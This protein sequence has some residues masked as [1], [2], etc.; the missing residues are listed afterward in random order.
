MEFKH[1]LHNHNLTFI[2]VGKEN[3]TMSCFGC[4]DIICGPAYVCEKCNMFDMHK[5]CA[6]LPPQMQRDAFHPHPLRFTLGN[7]IVCDRCAIWRAFSFSYSCMNCTFNL[8]FR[9]AVTISND[10]ELANHEALQE[11]RRIKTTIHHF[12]HNHQLTRCKFS[13]L[14]TVLGKEIFK[15]LWKLEKPKCM[16][17]KQKLHDI[18]IYTCIPCRFVIH[19]SCVNDMPRQVLQG[20]FHPQH[21]LLPRLIHKGSSHRCSA[22][23]EEVKGISFYCNQC[24]VNMHV[25]CA[26]Y[27]TRAIKHNCHPHHRLHLGKSIISNISCDACYK[28]C[29]DS[30]FGC[31]KC[32]FYIDVECIQLPLIVK[33][34]RHLHPLVLKNLFVEDDSGDYYCDM[35]ETER[36][37]EHHVYFC[38]EC[39]YIAPIDCVL[40]EVEPTEEMFSNQ[41]TGRNFDKAEIA[42]KR[43]E[44][45][46][47]LVHDEKKKIQS[48]MFITAKNGTYIAI[49]NCVNLVVEPPEEISKYLV[50]RPRK[51][52]EKADK[53]REILKR[54]MRS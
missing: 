8:D 16:A 10:C 34:K 38:K 20:P 43:M 36:N 39:T 42:N 12:N 23:K 4:R 9:C 13:L 53:L 7:V 27:R 31:I 50:P 17:C 33:H 28:D 51:E 11:G 22:C 24:D 46:G 44:L 30:F 40:P 45:E 25:S 35:C 6:E 18:L 48:M 49:I 54:K 26:K 52:K 21:I 41:R 29:D 1:F 14:K 15:Y 47:I 37:A 2:E 5:S 32:D 3:N 19:E